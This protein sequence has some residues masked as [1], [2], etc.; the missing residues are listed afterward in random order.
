MTKKLDA[1]LKK[2]ERVEAEIQKIQA[3]ENRKA[4]IFAWQEF[5]K[6]A[7]LPDEILKSALVKI[8][9]ENLSAG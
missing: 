4:E 3:L 8:V 2:R 6:I 5:Q 9:Q 7:E 1:L